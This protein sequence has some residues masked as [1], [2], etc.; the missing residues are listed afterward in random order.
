MRKT[1]TV[2]QES[3]YLGKKPRA[4]TNTINKSFSTAMTRVLVLE[5]CS[6]KHHSTLNK[7]LDLCPD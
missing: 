1:L 2:V 5:H 7:D 3:L 6:L 4:E